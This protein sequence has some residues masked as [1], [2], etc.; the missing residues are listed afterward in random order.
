MQHT[1]EKISGNKV[2][3][4]FQVTAAEFDAAAEKAYLKNR[5]R[6]NVPGFRKGKAPRKLMERMFGDTVFYDDALELLFPDAYMEAVTAED[7]HT[8]SQPE[9]S[10][11]TMEKGQDVTFSCEVFVQPEVKLGEY[12]G[13]EITRT[14]REVAQSQ[15]DSRLAQE[16]KRVA[17]SIEVTD[18]PV[19]A[20]DEVNL[21][22]SGTVD[23]VAFAGGTANGQ[24]LA[25][26]SN[27]FIPGFE[28][29]MIGMKLGEEKDLNVKFP[30]EYHA[31][32]LKG[33]DAVF[34]VKVN[35]ITREELPELDDDFASEV[36]DFDTLDA[37]SAD[38]KA[39]LQATADE[40]ATEDAKQKLVQAVV[41]N[42]ELDLP[43]PMVEDK[44]NDLLNDMNWRMKQQGFDLKKYM[45]LTGQTEE[46]MRA[47]YRDEARN[48][49]KTELVIEEIIKAEDVQADEKDV[50]EML[51]DYARSTG[52]TAEEFKSGLS[53][54]QL[55]YFQHHSKIRKTLDLLWS[56]AKVTDEAVKE[57]ETDADESQP[58]KA[59]TRKAPAKKA[60]AKPKA[61]KAKAAE[62][63][64]KDDADKADEATEK[65]VEAEDKE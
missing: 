3:I 20:G 28:E 16:Q 47:M 39:K 6:I 56:N 7:L 42:V 17:R 45:E 5:G 64:T 53:D 52:K 25:I 15:V 58:K 30:D 18:L 2:K 11:D 13:I 12:K 54:A 61:T 60:A 35:S 62:A 4:T 10:V 59:P 24:K 43:A 65:A 27:S 23:G 21:D 48:N 9:L 41:D 36:S 46:Q 32:D 51:A 50:D 40:Q 57:E 29:Q 8:V 19:E 34:H 22:Y 1:V 14:L 26:G 49:L 55:A 37:F 31:E 63:D 44:L 33:K 38:I